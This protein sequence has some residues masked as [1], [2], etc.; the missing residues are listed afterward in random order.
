MTPNP[1]RCC[2]SCAHWDFR[3]KLMEEGPCACQ[4]SPLGRYTWSEWGTECQDFKPK[5][6]DQ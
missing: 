4:K 6:E 1:P 5:K 3:T 2:G